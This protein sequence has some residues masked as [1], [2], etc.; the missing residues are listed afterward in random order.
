MDPNPYEAPT[1]IS[2]QP[3][4][5]QH[6]LLKALGVI[7]W[8]LSLPPAAL[9]LLAVIFKVGDDAES[10]LTAGAVFMCPSIGL[11]FIGAACWWRSIRFA[12]VGLFAFVP[13]LV[14]LLFRYVYAAFLHTLR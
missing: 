12:L 9:F 10:Y 5:T 4:Q 8:I 14:L 7:A 11:A 3:G 1:G 6:I 13:L 2:G